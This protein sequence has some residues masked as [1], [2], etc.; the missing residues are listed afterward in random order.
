MCCCVRLQTI[1]T[2]STYCIIPSVGWS[3]SSHKELLGLQSQYIGK[4]NR[5]CTQTPNVGHYQTP[6]K[7]GV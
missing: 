1:D 5:L 7:E 3:G 4:L 6:R 2:S